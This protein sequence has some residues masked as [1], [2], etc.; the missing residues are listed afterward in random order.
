MNRETPPGA[1]TLQAFPTSGSNEMA[2]RIN[3][4]NWSRTS[5]GP[6]EGWPQSLRTALG[7]LLS[8]RFPMQLLWGEEYVH[9]YNDAYLPIAAD[10]H[11]DALGQ[12]GAAIWPE[13]WHVVGPMLDE[14]RATGEATWSD[15]QLLVLNRNGSL[16]EGYF[17][18]SYGP[19]H[20]DSGAVD[21]IFIAVTETTR[22]V[23]GERRLRT[24]RDLGAALARV[25]EEEQ[26]HH[27]AC[28]VFARSDADLPFAL[29]YALREG[30]AFELVCAV[31][32]EAGDEACGRWPLQ[33]ALETRQ[34]L[35][36]EG[37]GD[38]PPTGPW[39]VPAGA[40]LV[41]PLLPSA[42]G[43]PV[44]CMVAGISSR[45]RLDAD[46]HEFLERISTLLA[47]AIASARAYAAANRAVRMRD[48][49][50]SIAAHEL[51]TPLTPIIG[52]LQLI[53]RR[54]AREGVDPRHL[55]AIEAVAV[56]AERLTAMIDA[57]LDLSRLRDGQLAIERAPL[58][59]REIA[60]R[61]VDEVQST[62]TGH[63]ITLSLDERPVTVEGDALRL[64]QVVRNL[65]SNAVKYSPGGGDIGLSVGPQGH[66][67]R[68]VVR[69]EG[70]GI[71]RE[72]LPQLFDRYYRADN[73][74]EAS[75]GGLGVG[76]FV[77]H[78]IVRLHGGSINVESR[79]GAGSNFTVLLPSIAT[80][81]V[82]NLS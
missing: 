69:D 58:D 60:R 40:A 36:V 63:T 71:P 14:V 51:K 7:I 30:Q 75:V 4:F 62:L 57:L 23:V 53:R 79:L 24:V 16:E 39:E 6:I 29:V 73:V 20:G 18:F 15:D 1:R 80:P 41:I 42:I 47:N 66:L 38:W 12:I 78:E 46:Y 21:G 72:A 35:L 19:V 81:Q 17:T 49:F 10:K 8:S 45:A 9:F 65:V 61:I 68:L 25:T 59:L 31:P 54:L 34:S 3:A 70:I 56:D 26:L 22:R 55:Q 27:V 13:V 74:E 82:S 48:D 11:P 67:V 32:P 37:L 64:E 76:L 77:A 52:R 33:A 2:G 50:L 5:L 28:E 44:G 43:Q